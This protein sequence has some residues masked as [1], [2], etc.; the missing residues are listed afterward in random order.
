M[1]ARAIDVV[2]H[3]VRDPEGQ[4]R[5]SAIAEV[6]GVEGAELRCPALYSFDARGREKGHV[7]G[8]WSCTGRSLLLERFEA[9]GASLDRKWLR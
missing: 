1:I 4:R 9:A 3:V 7:V 5:V 2:V 8:E 6:E